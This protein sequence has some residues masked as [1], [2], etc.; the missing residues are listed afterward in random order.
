[1]P[2][3]ERFN[4]GNAGNTILLFD[5]AIR[6]YTKPRDILTDYGSQFYSVRGGESS[7]DAY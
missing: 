5:R 6:E 1:V 7:F 3:S 4:E 2:G